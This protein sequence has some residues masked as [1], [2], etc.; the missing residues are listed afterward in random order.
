MTA[1]HRYSLNT[2]LYTMIILRRTNFLH[3]RI[4]MPSQWLPT[5][6]TSLY[7]VKPRKSHPCFYMHRISLVVFWWRDCDY[8]YY[9]D[10][11]VEI[12][13]PL[14]QIPPQCIY[15]YIRATSIKCN[16]ASLKDVR[17]A[18]ASSTS[19]RTSRYLLVR[20]RLKIRQAKHNI[21]A[22]IFA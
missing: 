14:R 15:A 2:Y 1:Y 13:Q 10:A 17:A 20:I 11:D 4:F 12:D 9:D 7:V 6:T 8:D 3:Q 5:Q 19:P 16:I 21:V 18:Y 22:E